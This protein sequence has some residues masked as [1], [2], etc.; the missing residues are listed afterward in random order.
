MNDS[1]QALANALTEQMDVCNELRR[2]MHDE[3][4][5]II[6]LDTARMEELN[7]L[8]EQAVLRQRRSADILKNAMAQ[9]ARQTGLDTKSS[10]SDLIGKLPVEAAKKLTP[11]Q[12]ELQ[13]TGAAVAE[14]AQ[15][16]K[17]VLERFLGTVNNSLG[18]ITRVLNSSNFYGSGGTYLNNERTGAMIVNREA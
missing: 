8:K 1:V 18:F 10:L 13:Q 6:A 2:L 15:Q 4:Q 12:R 7:S 3:Q 5:A 9:L 16:N 14:L 11:L 17:E